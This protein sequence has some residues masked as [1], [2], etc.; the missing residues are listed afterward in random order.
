MIIAGTGPLIYIDLGRDEPGMK[1]QREYCEGGNLVWRD[2]IEDGKVV[3]SPE[4][5]GTPTHPASRSVDVLIQRLTLSRI[6]SQGAGEQS[7]LSIMS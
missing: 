2:V 1:L 4:I 5:D 3:K 6:S 7:R